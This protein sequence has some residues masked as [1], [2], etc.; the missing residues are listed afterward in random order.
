M[1][2]Y[3]ILFLILLSFL[4]TAEA[5][6]PYPLYNLSVS[7]DVEKNLL[8]GTAVITLT[9]ERGMTIALGDLKV[10]SV[11]VNNQ[12]VAPDSKNHVL[13]L[14]GK[15]LAE[16]NYEAT[17]GDGYETG[18]LENT[19]VVTKNFIGGKGISLTRMWHPS[20]AEMA[21]YN[22]KALM[23]QG[24]TAVSEADDVT[25]S[26]TATGREFSFSFPNPLN[27]ITLAAGKYNEFKDSFNGIGI[28]AYFFSEDAGL[29]TKYLEYAKKYLQLYEGLIAPYPYKR[30]SVVENFLPTGYSMPSFTLLGQDVVRLPFIA[31][32]ALGH[33]ILHQWF[34]NSVYVDFKKGNWSEGL[35]AYLSDHL[36][37]DRKG[38]GRQYRKNILT[39]YANYVHAEKEF[40]LKYFISRTDFAS[41][42]IGY[43]KGAMVFHMLKKLVGDE[44]FFN[45]LK[46][47]AKER[48]FQETSWDDLRSM[49]EK[50]SGRN[51]EGFF[52]QWV[53]RKG[54]P[55]IEIDDPKV[56]VLKGIPT[57][58]FQVIQKD[59][60]YALDLSLSIT[61]DK[62]ALNKNIHID[63]GKETI[64]IPSDGNPLE[65]V[66]DADYD[67]MRRMSQEESPPV[68]SGLLGENKRLIVIPE[69][70]K[71]TYASFIDV[72]KGEG[73]AVKDESDIT[74]EDIKSSS[75]LVLGPDSPVLKRL[76][77]MSGK[78][79]QGF[80]LE[81][82]KNPLNISRVIAIAD[83]AS[84]DE[85]DAA[86][87]KIF[88]YGKYSALRF[89]KGRNV[90]KSIK[91]TEQG[92]R[93]VLNGS[94]TGIQPKKAMHLDEI[95]SRIYRK[96][97]I[98]IGER[99][100]NYEDHKIQLKV[101][102]G[103]H[104]KG[105]K[106]A[107]GME[108][109]QRPFQKAIND[110]LAG[111]INE[112]QF[113][114][115][116]EYFKRW[117]FDY[118]LYRE[119]IE[120]AKAKNI[121]IVALN[122]WSEITKKVAKEGLDGLD[123][124]EK[125]EIPE[126]MDMADEEYKSLLSSVF[127]S[128]RQ[129]QGANFDHFYESQ[130]L[131]DETMANTAD[132]FLKKNPD[133]QMVVLAGVGHIMHGYGIPKRLFRLNG[134]D[135]VTLIPSMATPDEDIADYVLFP[136]PLQAPSALKLGVVLKEAEG[137]LRIEEIIPGSRIKN[138]GVK[139]GD[140][141]FSLD[142]WKVETID[143]VKIFMFDRKEGDTI[144]I[145]VYRKKLLSGYH[146]MEFTATL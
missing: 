146:T 7:F 111:A 144:K 27:E 41:K 47:I 122:Q 136:E 102:M 104:E 108:M 46:G 32:T 91:E 15:G 83:A 139:K 19:G 90:G 26:E 85:A 107:V 42:A 138:S 37:E 67:V 87:R 21:L 69:E 99:H 135:F 84:K 100:G 70:K 50:E 10:L 23:P 145:K 44:V 141:L 81:V 59:E 12:P 143:D 118:N 96:P 126:G 115:S 112:K 94:V 3:I 53:N 40:P 124:L 36:Y 58:S 140:V 65:M 93:F 128:H 25:V 133:R 33:E 130:L 51:L 20:I 5:V 92:M 52:T 62:G 134:K 74:D 120:F 97:V 57:V 142:D 137:G 61:T 8:K 1:K 2:K 73:F 4:S 39:D 60:P 110:Y 16:I 106:F 117:Q 113:L 34:G 78:P 18:G 49:F 43:G 127:K 17:F 77:G 79:G 125:R 63:K 31:E 121:P 131:W 38:N 13:E 55:L 11:K 86:V 88:H 71:D 109:F 14:K 76:F 54:M 29:G 114:K 101:I 72:F 80:S 35:T 123:F 116:T 119:I 89:E 9:E 64:E 66:I 22:L 95:I 129:L 56:I 24:F 45:A 103:L 132:E 105:R 48:Q 6:G 82:R 75:L 98:Y 28:Y 30:F 68:I